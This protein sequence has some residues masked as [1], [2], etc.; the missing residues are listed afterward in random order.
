VVKAIGVIVFVITWAL[1]A[2]HHVN[3]SYVN[4]HMPWLPARREH[5]CPG[6]DEL[7]R[8]TD[9]RNHR[10]VRLCVIY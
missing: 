3:I 2:V 5:S 6:M 4:G 8:A 9:L 10:P 1:F 7:P